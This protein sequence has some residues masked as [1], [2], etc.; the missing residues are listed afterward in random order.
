[1][2]DLP[3]TLTCLVTQITLDGSGSSNWGTIIYE[4]TTNDGNIVGVDNLPSVNVNLPGTYQLFLTDTLTNET[5]F[6]TVVVEINNINPIADAGNPDT[7]NCLITSLSLNGSASSIGN[8]FIY[9]WTTSNG[10][11]VSGSG[12]IQPLI[13]EG[14]TY[15]LLVTNSENGCTATSS[16][17]ITIDTI[18]PVV[19]VGLPDDLNCVDTL[20]F[21]NGLSSST[22]NNF[23]YEW[24][25]G[26]GNIVGDFTTLTPQINGAGTYELTVINNENF[27][28]ATNE[29]LIEIDT[30]APT[31]LIEPTEMLNCDLTELEIDA[32]GSSSGNNFTIQWQT[33]N[34]NIV[35]GASSLS[36]QINDGGDYELTILNTLNGCSTSELITVFQDTLVPISDAGNTMELNCIDTVLTLDGSNSS[37]GIDFSYQWQTF[38]GNI[39][40]GANSLFPNI[41]L[42]GDYELIVTDNNN[43]CTSVSQVQITQDILTPIA[44]I[45]LPDTLNCQTETTVLSAVNSSNGLIYSYLWSTNNGNIDFGETSQNPQV[46][47][48]G[49]YVLE[50]TNNENG[51]TSTDFVE[52]VQD[53]ILP[54]SEAGVTMTLTCVDTIL[55]LAGDGSSSGNEFTYEWT[56]NDGNLLNGINSLNPLIDEQ[57]I[58]ELEV[59]NSNN[60][61]TSSDFVEILENII[62]PVVEINAIGGLILN[63]DVNSIVLDAS[64]SSPIGEVSFEWSTTNGNITIGSTDPN[65]EVDLEGD[66]QLILTNEINGCTATEMVQIGSDFELPIVQIL[67]PDTLTCLDTLVTVSGSGSSTGSE[68]EYLWTHTLGNIVSGETELECVVNEF[69]GYI[70]TVLNT[71]NG[72]MASK[73]VTV[74]Q[75]IEEPLADAG[76]NYEFDCIQTVKTLQGNGSQ[77]AEFTYQWTTVDGNITVGATTL[78]PIVDAFGTYVLTVT[79]QENGCT[80]TSTAIVTEDLDVPQDVEL[81]IISPLCFGDYNGS[82]EVMEVIGGEE[83]Y[84]YSINENTFTEYPLFSNLPAGNYSLTIQDASGCEWNSM[85]EITEPPEVMVSL[86]E[87]I[88]LELGE[89]TVLQAMTNISSFDLDSVNWINIDNLECEDCLEQ[90]I[91]PL[92]TSGYGVFLMNENGCAT[93]DEIIVYVNNK[94]RIYIPNAFSPNGD[95]YNDI[96]MIYGG[97]GIAEIETFQI[98][99]RWGDLV[100]ERSNFQPNDPTMGWDG[101]FKGEKMNPAVFV[102][103]AKIKYT[104]GET[105]IMKGDLFLK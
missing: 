53:T 77:G 31:I 69:G 8:N 4:W 64:S 2:I 19:D 83:P 66:Y 25:T 28:E 82:I 59:T 84:L 37:N 100:F 12:E 38:N 102:F 41:D 58:Y 1:M 80:A 75:D 78:Q 94:K 60:M 30:I 89:S 7:L 72:C 47:D 81:E 63:C 24:T 97:L 46:S 73:A 87:D 39:Q 96:F 3:D 44:I 104:N 70:L 88:Y 61:C 85:I 56:T 26:D 17:L 9:E 22:G 57:G 99:S 20:L 14:G 67:V 15:D 49:Q 52:V 33:Q 92:F 11:I 6:G 40:S 79:N 36:P 16:V 103:F 68:F 86:G 13:D 65:P 74:Y 71:E 101:F 50:I 45:D 62:P 51:C 48:G 29:I 21:L 43:M 54:I 91:T 35:N 5:A 18:L 98:F 76:G 34:G 90:A 105:E 42:L 10:N 27:C 23:A 32:N 55:I 95:G 93:E